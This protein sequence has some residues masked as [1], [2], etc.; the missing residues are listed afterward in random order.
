MPVWR[1]QAGVR[2]VPDSLLQ[3]NA[4]RTGPR[5]HALRRTA[6]GAEAPVADAD[7]PARQVAARGAS[8]EP[9]SPQGNQAPLLESAAR[10]RRAESRLPPAEIVRIG[11][12]EMRSWRR[13]AQLLS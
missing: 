4:A 2:Q 7:P 12:A 11:R 1:G 13:I 9:S 5:H 8:D 10:L 6:H 3:E